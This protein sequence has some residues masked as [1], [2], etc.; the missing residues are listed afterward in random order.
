MS[1][2]PHLKV[3]IS[4]HTDNVGSDVYNLKL[5][6]RRAQSVVRYLTEKGANAS[7]LIAKGYGESKPLV[8]NDTDENKAKN[9]RVE[10]S[11]LEEGN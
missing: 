4:A 10:M 7:N 11:I 2:N 6:D 1:K 5:S 8:A 3:E 9:R